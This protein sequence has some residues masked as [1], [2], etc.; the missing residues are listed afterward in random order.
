MVS[1]QRNVCVYAKASL[2]QNSTKLLVAMCVGIVLALYGCYVRSQS[3]VDPHYMPSVSVAVHW[4]NDRITNNVGNPMNMLKR[5]CPPTKSPKFSA[6]SHVLGR[7]VWGPFVSNSSILNGMI[8]IGQIILLKVWCS[9][10]RATNAIMGL[11]VL[12]LVVS[13]VCVVSA[14]ASCKLM[15]L[16]CLGIHHIAII[17]L[18]IIRNRILANIFCPPLQA[19]PA[20]CTFGSSNASRLANGLSKLSNQ[21]PAK[22]L[23]Q[24]RAS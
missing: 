23:R 5:N 1:E 12:G 17:Y 2:K 20:A 14:F 11:S 6:A 4:L 21:T 7:Y 13:A 10:I 3:K 9:S 18:A 15:C 19:N 22:S 24:R 8:N 16:S